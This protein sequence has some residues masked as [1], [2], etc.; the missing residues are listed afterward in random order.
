MSASSVIAGALALALAGKVGY[1]KLKR[2]FTSD[3]LRESDIRKAIQ[4]REAQEAARVNKLRRI[5]QSAHRGEP[6]IISG[7][8]DRKS[9]V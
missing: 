7:K 8:R 1:P 3:K 9:V 2:L 5:K 6:R 4:V